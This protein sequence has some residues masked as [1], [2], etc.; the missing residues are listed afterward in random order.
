M[1]HGRMMVSPF[2]FYRGAAKIMAADLNGTPHAGLMAQLCG[3]AHLS[4][5]GMFGSPERALLFDVNDF[6]E[7]ASRAVR[8]RRQTA[9]RELHDR[10]TE[11]R[12]LEDGHAGRHARLGASLPRGDGRLR[13]DGNAG[14]LVCPPVRERADGGHQTGADQARRRQ[15]GGQGQK[16]AKKDEKGARAIMDKARTRDSLQALS[17]LAEK[18]DGRYRIVS[19]PPIVVPVRELPASAEMTPDEVGDVLTS[20]S[21]PIGQ[22]CGATSAICWS[23]SSSSTSRA[24]SSGSGAS[25]RG[26]ISPSF[27]VATSRTRSSSRSRR[28]RPRC[29]K[30]TS[31]RVG[32]S[33]PVSGWCR[34]SG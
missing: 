13:A 4:N 31:R 16:R 30:T 26:R 29:S 10:G 19:Q 25:G 12:V 34:G 27:R 17:K 33:N 20:S 5:F 24:R 6:D 22:P 32:S 8:V 1:R 23:D 21:A 9:G 28:R 3:D 7:N 15:E 11:Q 18:V 2:T 14:R